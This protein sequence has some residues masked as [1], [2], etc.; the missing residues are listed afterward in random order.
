MLTV[1]MF[2]LAVAAGTVTGLNNGVAIT[3]QMGWNSWNHFACGINET[4]YRNTILALVD[5]G[6]AGLG[7]TYAN[8]DDCWAWTR[9]PNGTIGV[10]PTTFP[11]GIPTLAEFAHANHLK[12]GLYTDLGIFT[13]AGRPG[14]LGYEAI[15]AITYAEWK[16]DYVKVDN[17]NQD[18]PPEER[19]P[20]M[21]Q[22]LNESGRTI[23]FSMCEWGVDDPAFWA[24]VVGNSWRTTGDIKDNWA[25]MT[26]RADLNEPLYPFAGPG[27]WNDPDMLEVGNGGMTTDE[28]QAHFSLWSLMKAPLLIGCDITAMSNDTK[29]ILMNQEV[30]AWSQDALGV[31]GRRVWSQ[32][33]PTM[34]GSQHAAPKLK[35]RHTGHF[36]AGGAQQASLREDLFATAAIVAPCDATAS[37]QQ[38]TI[39][40]AASG[41]ITVS[42]GR[43][44]DVDYCRN[45]TTGN[46]VSV[47]PCHSGGC[48]NGSN[49]VWTYSDTDATIKTT[50]D[51][52]CLEAVPYRGDLSTHPSAA[53][54]TFYVQTRPCVAGRA[55]QQWYR[56][57]SS[58]VSGV[59]NGTSANMCLSLFQDVAPGATEVWAGPLVGNAIAV[60]LFNRGETT[61]NITA[62]WS[63]IG[64]RD[65]AQKMNVRDVVQHVSLGV[66]SLQ[67]TATVGPHAS[68]SLQLSPASDDV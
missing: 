37:D 24:P 26:N 16:V 25:A 33:T 10:D 58:I 5:T 51:G 27:G 28:Y 49:E 7:Y 47:Y 63:A 65:N 30:I 23:F 59:S 61:S 32:G 34:E 67:F 8:L 17:C 21:S 39:S 3:P 41:S 9:N 66:A 29:A 55:A 44:L 22:S 18:T 36:H 13:C 20:V 52:M 68:M 45:W 38:W 50:M 1:A 43:C 35:H 4:I 11:S 62:N 14:S 53:Y 54:R 42:D 31:Q 48:A 12:F 56:S 40:D 15:D 64:I 60:L 6:L 19:Y 57:G 46:H 2:L